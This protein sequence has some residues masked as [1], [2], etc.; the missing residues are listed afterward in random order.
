MK[1]TFHLLIFVV[2]FLFCFTHAF[3]SK[4]P[5]IIKKLGI[6]KGLSNNYILS[7]A[8]DSSGF[9]W[10]GT[11]WGLNRFDGN[12]FKPFVN[13]P[14][15]INS[16]GDNGINKILADKVNNKL[17][18]ATKRA[19][20]NVFDYSTEKI[21]RYPIISN[22]KNSTYAYGITDLCFDRQGDIWIATYGNGLKKLMVEQDSII[23]LDTLDIDGYIWSVF[24]D[25]KGNL[26]IGHSFGGLSIVSL[27][28][29]TVRKFT[30]HPDDPFSLPSNTILKVYIDSK[31]NIWLCTDN[32]L[33]IFDPQT[34]R[35]HT[36]RHDD[37]NPRS[38]CH[39]EILS[40]VEI[41]NILWVGTSDG[42]SLLDL[43]R[44]TMFDR[45]EIQFD[46]IGSNDL[47]TGLSNGIV[48]DIFPD[49][50]G[51]IW[52]GTNRAVNFISHIR[53]FFN[54][55]KY[56]AI[57]DDENSLAD[58]VATTI[59][60]D[61]KNE[62]LWVG[63][64]K[65][66]VDVYH[67]MKKTAHYDEKEG[68]LPENFLVSS[69]VDSSGNVWL[70]TNSKGLLRLN[71]ESNRFESVNLPSEREYNSPLPINCLFEDDARNLWIGSNHALF[72]Y[73][74]A[75]EAISRFTGDSV[76]LPRNL[77]RS[78]AQD[79]NGNLWLG[80]LIDGLSIVTPDLKLVRNRIEI[81]GIN[82]IYRDSK[83]AM[84]VSS[85]NGA[86]YFSPEN[87]YSTYQAVNEENGLADG[88][89]YAVV[90]GNNGEMWMSTNTGISLY[91]LNDKKIENYNHL[92]GVPHGSF[93]IGSVKKTGDGVIC[94]GSQN[95]VC[96]F[97]SKQSL[98]NDKVPPVVLTSFSVYD[99]NKGQS[100]DLIS[101]PVSQRIK[102]AYNQNNF[103]IDFNVM[104]YSLSDRVEY[105]YAMQGIDDLWYTITGQNRVTFR[106]LSPGKYMFNVKA[107]LKNQLWPDDITTM[108]I[109]VT[110]PFWLTWWAKL[111]Y[112]LIAGFIVY[113]IISY[114]IER[115]NKQ[116]EHELN[117]EKLRFYTNVTHELKTPLTLI[118]GP[119]ADLKEDK[120]LDADHIGKISMIHKNASKL[121]D[122]T[123]QIIEF[124]KTETQNRKLIVEKKDIS[125]LV[126]EIVLKY[127]ELNQNKHIF[128]SLWKKTNN[129]VIYF[130]PEVITI[131]M[132]NLITNSIK[133][134]TRGSI[135]I[136]I[137]E[138]S[139]KG[140]KIIE[141]EVRDTGQG[142]PENSLDKIFKQYYQ[143]KGEYQASGT[144]IGL[145]LIKNLTL[146]HK[147]Q[148]YV[149]SKLNEGTSFYVH[150]DADNVY[151][152]ARHM[153]NTELNA[154]K[155]TDN[156]FLTSV[157][158]V[159][160]NKEIRQY[161]RESFT[162][163]YEILEAGNGK[164][165]VETA[166]EKIPDIIVSD[167]M[168]P[169]MD[170]INLCKILK[171]DVR[172]CHIPIILLTAK[173]SVLDKI[174]GY[175][176][177]ADSYITKPFNSFLLQSRIKNLLEAREKVKTF[178]SGNIYKK[179][180]TKDALCELDHEFM[181][182]TTSLIE[183]E[184][185]SE[186]LSAMFLAEQ[187][188][189]SYSAFSRK[190]K[191]VTGMTANELI[192]KLKLQRAEKMLLSRKY[193]I[194]EIAYRLGFNNMS[195]FRE[196]FKAE[197]GNT[198]SRY[199]KDIEDSEK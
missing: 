9:V 29:Y 160:D 118:L 28:D 138:I 131:I 103:V 191:G 40:V 35:T 86:Y 38:L 150:L 165:G 51:N 163:P 177:G 151:P 83:G 3:S 27:K 44:L 148:I 181:E 137:R 174:E 105:S 24:D 95:G 175:S 104:D 36:F 126:K 125:L 170:G 92:N 189:M 21:I 130:D 68:N 144:G 167:I 8:E 194:T 5:H 107:R 113:F 178:F 173:D 149:K 7:I 188:C 42:I 134:T 41:N 117:N 108:Q 15:D 198:P 37:K 172:T 132:D 72:R 46:Y 182:K 12:T 121:L 84:W 187:H 139:L 89:V 176:I 39:N 145:A 49:S 79:S 122:L 18:I 78:I 119:L 101:L 25:K 99:H 156:S 196:Y 50:Y 114:Y 180:I 71:K 45:S 162:G 153:E 94:F 186:Q 133:Y 31:E 184:M 88:C 54:T 90:E 120:Q 2:L 64:E 59:S 62:M 115:K 52:I 20:L 157:L 179:K 34:G 70:G 77:Y 140:K 6:E 171:G 135:D 19:G 65:G 61:E 43:K 10:V 147:A 55:L 110:P 76:M 158:I 143:V 26:Y 161:I 74:P 91:L 16:V 98:D 128:I 154:Q 53:P 80:T 100:N 136:Y 96:Y 30:Y 63:T 97:D 85:V 159:E 142:M 67:K 129:T 166:I 33:S 193:S 164:E 23:H 32:G 87:N 168:M 155:S 183:S 56:T 195:H 60:Y 4:D 146:L 22:E 47:P 199:L 111:I 152:D 190:I 14:R 109:V 106:N 81:N 197:F 112:V 11:E 102:L 127:T 116:K 1:H 169:V 124:R 13:N 48:R 66:G 141:I 75:S 69:L 73:N 17:W 57:R 82:H 58:R 192:R 185:E 123:N 93:K